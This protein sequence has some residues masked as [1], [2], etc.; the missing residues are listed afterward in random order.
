MY[1]LMK[2][3][4]GPINEWRQRMKRKNTKRRSTNENNEW[5]MKLPMKN[6]EWRT[7]K[8]DNEWKWERQM[9]TNRWRQRMKYPDPPKWRTTNEN[10]NEESENPIK[11]KAINNRV[12][13]KRKFYKGDSFFMWVT[14]LANGACILCINYKLTQS[15]VY[16]TVS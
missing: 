6:N 3:Q 8:E 13:R 1:T 15:R 14:I 9:K 2:L 7:T 12:R 4:S 16:I 11:Q 5:K 10:F